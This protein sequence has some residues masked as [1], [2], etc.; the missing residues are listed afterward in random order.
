VELDIRVHVRDE[1]GRESVLLS[2]NW[3]DHSVFL[4][5]RAPYGLGTTLS[6][7]VNLPD[8]RE[9]AELQG[10]VTRIVLD[11]GDSGRP[12]G[13]ALRLSHF[14]ENLV[15][16]LSRM[17]SDAVGAVSLVGSL[18][19]HVFVIGAAV[20]HRNAVAS[21]LEAD[22]FEVMEADDCAEA[23]DYATIGLLSDVV[24]LLNEDNLDGLLQSLDELS[25][26]PQLVVIVGGLRNPPAPVN[27]PILMT[28][29][30]MPNEEL[31][32]AIRM[33]VPARTTTFEVVAAKPDWMP[34]AAGA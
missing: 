25:R 10:V 4:R 15:H 30:S 33:L 20:A 27:L 3:G 17:S 6:G 9:R 16:Y 1:Q 24:V 13:M 31:S 34:A 2:H 8:S 29:L 22:E 21:Q 7:Y 11:E 18:M 23:I 28:P 5:T 26:P 14:P 32:A 19:P 12:S